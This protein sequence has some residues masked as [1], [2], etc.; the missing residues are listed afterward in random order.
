MKIKNKSERDRAQGEMR[1][2]DEFS[3]QVPLLEVN[4]EI[5]ALWCQIR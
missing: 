5:T 2:E 3:L 4:V 1:K